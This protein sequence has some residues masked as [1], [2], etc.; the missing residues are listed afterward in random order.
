MQ[1]F[2]DSF[3]CAT[4]FYCLKKSLLKFQSTEKYISMRRLRYAREGGGG[5]PKVTR[6]L[7]EGGGKKRP[8]IRLHNL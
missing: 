8:K 5:R 1:E 3:L 4:V 2:D 7:R 6:R